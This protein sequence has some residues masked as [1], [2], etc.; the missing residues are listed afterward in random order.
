[1]RIISS[2]DTENMISTFIFIT[3]K[4]TENMINLYF[5]KNKSLLDINSLLKE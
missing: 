5:I 4:H 3:L 2:Q 1:M